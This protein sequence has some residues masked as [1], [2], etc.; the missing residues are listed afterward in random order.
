M[1]EVD[2]FYV[3]KK[4]IMWL[5]LK[6]GARDTCSTDNPP[7]VVHSNTVTVRRSGTPRPI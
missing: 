5:F 2:I 4:P 6:E 7:D 1:L 3:V